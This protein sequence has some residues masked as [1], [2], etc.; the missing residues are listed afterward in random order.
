MKQ[1]VIS[2]IVCILA[3]SGCKK[4]LPPQP[5]YVAVHKPTV[6]LQGDLDSKDT[7][8]IASNDEWVV[9]LE[10]GVDWISVEPSGGSGDGMIVIT[11]ITRNTT[12]SRK[13][14]NVEVKA[15]NGTANRLI[16]VTQMQFNQ[17]VVN[18]IFGGEGTDSFSDFTST[19]DGGY[20]AVGNSASTQGDGTG[21]KGGTD[22]WVVKFNSEGEKV[23]HKK[24][25]G[26]QEDLASSI[27]RTSANNYLILGSTLSNDGD[28]S[29]NKGDR[30][31]W[32]LSIDNDGTLLWEKAIGGTKEEQL[33]SLK[34]SDDG[35]YLM[36]GWTYSND[37]DVSFNHGDTDAWLV[38]IDNQGTVLWEK[39][40]G[41]SHQDVAFDATPVS[42]GGM[43]FC[44]RLV[45]IDGDA[46]DRTAETFAG[47]FVKLNSAGTIAGKVYLGATEFD[48]GSVAIEAANGDYVFAGS[49][50][51]A[52]AFD[53]FH[54]GNDAF[55]LRLDASGNV[56]WKKAY[57]GSLN[58][59]P[60]D[61]IETDNGDFIFAG[62][63]T[64]DDGDIPQLLGGEDAW[65]MKLNGEG[66]ITSNATLGG[67]LND[68]VNKIKQLNDDNFAFVGRTASFEDAY[69]DLNEGTHGWFQI[70]RLN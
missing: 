57:G 19:P 44:G 1:L 21:A 33:F 52:N 47:W 65:V 50:N 8:Y 59:A 53:N 9:T 45:S 40:Y 28:V 22:V 37:G 41:G 16:T 56:R 14:T 4:S 69:P 25:G 17:I 6:T 51:T 34:S 48:Y 20:M 35:N 7:I 67:A 43:I 58:E 64:S 2:A 36:A 54:G 63:T 62:L 10:S 46:S 3:L 24:F 55:V 42:D 29:V 26:T 39:T 32:L 31:A 66:I 27:V 12:A 60:S 13:T 5:R 61:L 68:K 23:W 18:A 49:T 30:D 70:I 15:V 38:K 11:T